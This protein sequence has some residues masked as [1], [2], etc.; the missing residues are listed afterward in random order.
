MSKHTN[1]KWVEKNIT[2]IGPNTYRIRVGSFDG[3]AT[4]RDSARAV[5]RTFLNKMG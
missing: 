2:K 4:S 1:Y 5:K 3:Y